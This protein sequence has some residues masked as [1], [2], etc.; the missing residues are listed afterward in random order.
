MLEYMGIVKKSNKNEKINYIIEYNMFHPSYDLDLML[1]TT[2][3]GY[4][5]CSFK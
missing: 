2:I 1:Y 3:Y 4:I 5:L